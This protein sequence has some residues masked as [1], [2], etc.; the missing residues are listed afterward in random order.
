MRS[1]AV[2]TMAAAELETRGLKYRKI[3][4]ISRTKSQNLNVPRLGMQFSWCNILK[5]S[6]QEGCPLSSKTVRSTSTSYHHLIGL[7]EIYLTEHD[8]QIPSKD[9]LAGFQMAIPD[10]I[11]AGYP[12]EHPAVVTKH[13]SDHKLWCSVKHPKSALLV[14]FLEKMAESN[15]ICQ[16]LLWITSL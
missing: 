9:K 5:P 7:A 13:P 1:R 3:S 2:N 4:K 10:T 12:C 16:K 8:H 11:C 15:S 6:V 14:E